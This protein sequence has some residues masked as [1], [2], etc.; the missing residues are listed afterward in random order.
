MAKKKTLDM[1]QP[2]DLS[3]VSRETLLNRAVWLEQMMLTQGWQLMEAIMAENIK[4]LEGQIITKSDG[5]TKFSEAEVD[6]LR[7]QHAQMTQ[8]LEK[9][10]QLVAQFRGEQKIGA[11]SDYDPYQSSTDKGVERERVQAGTLTSE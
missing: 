11:T 1:R 5:M 10:A 4:R 3:D 9:P 2:I 6:E 8:L 7:M